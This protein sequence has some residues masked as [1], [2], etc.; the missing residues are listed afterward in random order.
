MKIHNPN[1]DILPRVWRLSAFQQANR[2]GE[3]MGRKYGI[4]Q[5]DGEYLRRTV[6]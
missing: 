6:V 5:H 2:V 1:S 3:K 4:P